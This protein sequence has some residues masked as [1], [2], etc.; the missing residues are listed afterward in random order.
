MHRRF[1]TTTPSDLINDG[2]YK[3]LALSVYAGEKHRKVGMALLAK[4]IGAIPLKGKVRRAS[5]ASNLTPQKA[6]ATANTSRASPDGPHH[7]SSMAKLTAASTTGTRSVKVEARSVEL[8]SKSVEVEAISFE[9]DARSGEVES[10]SVEAEMASAQ[11][12][13]QAIQTR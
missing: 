9:A 13:F 10:R 6:G 12:D 5:T 7:L 2:L 11:A 4:S 1:F 3:A 8:E